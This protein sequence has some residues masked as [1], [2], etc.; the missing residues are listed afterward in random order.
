MARSAITS[1]VGKDEST[2]EV[3]EK[4]RV[5]SVARAV[6]I[7]LTVAQSPNGIKAV[8]IGRSAGLPRQATYH[9]IHTLLATGML[10][11]TGQARYVLGLRAGALGEAFRR[12]LAPQQHLAPLIRQVALDTGETSYASGWRD[13][14]VVN[15]TSWRGSNPVQATEVPEGSFD[16]GHARA[17]GK[18]LLAFASED[19]KRHYLATH[20][21]TRSTPNTISNEARFLEELERI[22]NQG[23][24][25]DNEEFC[26]GLTCL[27]VPLD[28]GASPFAL[29][30]AAPTERFATNFDRYLEALRKAVSDL[31]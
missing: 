29:T 12:Q 4:M 11:Q 17:S 6:K 22:R 7:L 5:Q 9:L 8:D 15:L 1:G 14:E 10:T 30:I 2:S 16:F 23:Y 31:V 19:I 25:I 18:V 28:R 20:P 21:L 24:A 3:G 13:G 26:I 27:S